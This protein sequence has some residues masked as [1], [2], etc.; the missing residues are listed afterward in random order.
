MEII[1][2]G[3]SSLIVEICQSFDS[4]ERALR[5]VLAAKAR[6][7]KAQIPGVV[8]CTSAYTTVGVYYD[9]IAVVR[10]G[11][12]PESIVEWLEPE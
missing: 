1:P 2:L 8:E 4:P 9:P 5:D 7:E 6:I 12:N 3:D 10:H 11:A